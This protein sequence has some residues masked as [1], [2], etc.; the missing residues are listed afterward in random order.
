MLATCDLSEVSGVNL[1][2][3]NGM[4]LLGNDQISVFETVYFECEE[5]FDLIGPNESTC[6]T[7]GSMSV[8]ENDLPTCVGKFLNILYFQADLHHR[9]Q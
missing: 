6:E 2:D 8:S 1:V 7:D 5:G 3:G 9:C 4:P